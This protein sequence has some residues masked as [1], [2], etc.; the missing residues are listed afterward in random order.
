MVLAQ[1]S[2]WTDYFY[3]AEEQLP[4]TTSKENKLVWCTPVIG[5]P[6][7][8]R[9]GSV[10]G[11]SPWSVEYFKCHDS[12]LTRKTYRTN[13]VFTLISRM[14]IKQPYLEN[15]IKL[16]IIIFKPTVDGGGYNFK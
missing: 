14:R 15:Q 5:L 4:N 8:I 13:F 2:K 10:L 9:G 7:P 16:G 3:R 12:K 11:A 1:M 6:P